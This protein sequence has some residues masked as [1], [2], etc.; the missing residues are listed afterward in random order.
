[1]I[2]SLSTICA[3]F[4]RLQVVKV[5]CDKTMAYYKNY[6]AIRK[7]ANEWLNTGSELSHSVTEDQVSDG[8][9]MEVSDSQLPCDCEHACSLTHDDDDDDDDYD[10]D[11]DNDDDDDD[12]SSYSSEEYSRDVAEQGSDDEIEADI[13][14]GSLQKE[15]ARWLVKCRITREA[16]NGLLAVLRRHGHPE[17][18]KDSRT[19]KKTPRTI[20]VID[21]CGGQY[22]YLGL[23]R[24]LYMVSCSKMT[25]EFCDLEVQIA[26]GGL[27]LF[28]SSSTLFWPIMCSVNNG[29]PTLVAL[30]VGKTKPDSLDEFVSDLVTELCELKETGF[31]CSCSDSS[32]RVSVKLHSFICDAP[33]RAFFKNIKGH[34]SLHACE[35]CEAVGVSVGNRTTFNFPACFMAEKRSSD[36]FNNLKYKGTHQNGSTPLINCCDNCVS[37]FPLDYMHL[38]CLG[39]VKCML[40]CWKGSERSERIVK[41]S[42]GQILNISEQLIKLRDCIPSDFVKRPR[43]LLVEQWKATEFCTFLLYTGPVVLKSVLSPALYK[44]F[45][46]LSVSLN[47][48]LR[49]DVTDNEPL[50][51]YAGRL[52]HHFVEN[53][54][55]LYGETFTVYNV[56]SLLHL[57]DDVKYF[58]T[59][60]NQLNAFPYE[61]Y[62]QSLKRLIRS[63]SSPLVQVAK[64]IEESE[65]AAPL[66]PVHAEKKYKIA[67]ES[68]DSTLFLKNGKFATVLEVRES[69][70][71]CKVFKRRN[72]KPF[73][74]EPC[75]SDLINI[76][77]V[78]SSDTV[79]I[80]EVPAASVHSKGLKLPHGNDFVLIPL[81]H[82]EAV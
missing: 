24:A 71:L 61:N 82:Q 72:L 68:R 74:S 22:I 10:D 16:G 69:T 58:R 62:L 43:S 51:D 49:D 23:K 67:P 45:L 73:Y 37:I 19:L 76:Y 56:H 70:F 9:D 81:L 1:M 52:L 48:L 17:L 42:S 18:P 12:Q 39:I 75:S 15:L 34:T 53:C 44:H 32:K 25:S 64:R 79:D 20:T 30:F 63:P 47:I 6:R 57:V 40:T 3:I 54:A 35:R 78:K 21:M 7:K 26:T 50:I 33:A 29:K 11:D 36:K 14:V 5:I 8:G 66:Q 31:Q 65:I 28:K 59:S 41:L 80:K 4:G 77:C 38:I 13:Q 60:L 2:E 55:S 46:T 27:P